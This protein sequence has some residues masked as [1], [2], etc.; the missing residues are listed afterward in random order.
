MAVPSQFKPSG[1]AVP[2]KRSKVIGIANETRKGEETRKRCEKESHLS[3]DDVV[4]QDQLVLFNN[5]ELEPMLL[6]QFGWNCM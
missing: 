6:R 5:N 2:N 4:E 3:R 1:P